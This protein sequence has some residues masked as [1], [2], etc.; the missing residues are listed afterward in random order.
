MV[1]HSREQLF[2]ST[3]LR[4]MCDRG[5]HLL[6]WPSEGSRAGAGGLNFYDDDDI[7]SSYDITY[8]DDDIT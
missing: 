6:L 2:I 4:Q 8:D 5:H 7:T 1:G 3:T